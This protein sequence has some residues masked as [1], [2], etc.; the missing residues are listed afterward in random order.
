M[1]VKDVRNE[2]K[3]LI[4]HVYN[5]YSFFLNDRH[6]SLWNLSWENSLSLSLF[7][8]HQI[9][10]EIKERKSSINEWITRNGAYNVT[11]FQKH[12]NWNWKRKKKTRKKNIIEC[13]LDESFYRFLS[14]SFAMRNLNIISNIKIWVQ[15]TM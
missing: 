2:K 1:N 8:L 11:H 7:L 3:A 9:K 12:G 13:I 6:I 15:P 5:T 10:Y 4:R 14:S